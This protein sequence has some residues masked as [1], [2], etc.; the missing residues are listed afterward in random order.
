VGVP[1][2]AEGEVK[3][4]ASISAEWK[5][6]KTTTTEQSW[7]AT[8]PVK[9]LPGER[10]R[11]KSSVWMGE[12]ECPYTLT[13]QTKDGFKVTQQGKWHG[14]LAWNLR[15]ELKAERADGAV[16]NIAV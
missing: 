9:A 15:H 6:G 10:I 2:V 13:L 4:S 5:Q 3:V 11:A 16:R 14:V 7:K 1:F 8:F 12:V